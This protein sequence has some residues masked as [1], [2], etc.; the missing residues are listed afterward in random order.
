[1]KLYA[2]CEHLPR[3]VA[4]IHV[5]TA[6]ANCDRENVLEAVYP[7]PRNFDNWLD[8]LSWIDDS[9]SEK[10]TTNIIGEGCVGLYGV[11]VRLGLR[12]LVDFLCV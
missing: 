7:P 12:L 8:L 2:L 1:M 11:W 9:D 6:Y 3:L 4:L 10:V 5:S